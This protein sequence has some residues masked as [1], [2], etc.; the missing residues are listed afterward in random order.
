M[1]K[2]YEETY[3][4]ISNGNKTSRGLVKAVLLSTLDFK[5]ACEIPAL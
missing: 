2:V 4:L 5:V 3:T 1:R